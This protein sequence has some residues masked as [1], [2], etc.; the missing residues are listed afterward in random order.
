MPYVEVV[1][2][3]QIADFPPSANEVLVESMAFFQKLIF[4]FENRSIDKKKGIHHPE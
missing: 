4:F 3:E 1:H 2:R